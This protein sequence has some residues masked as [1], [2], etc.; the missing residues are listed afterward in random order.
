MGQVRIPPSLGRDSYR[1]RLIRLA[2]HR[3]KSRQALRYALRG[4]ALF[5]SSI[6]TSDHA[7][8]E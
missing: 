6:G 4:R 1:A 5:Q 7:I 3:Q 2:G 8:A